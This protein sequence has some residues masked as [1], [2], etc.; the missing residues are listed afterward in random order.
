MA[1]RR[2]VTQG[3]WSVSCTT[4]Y[5]IDGAILHV[6]KSRTIGNRHIFQNGQANGLHFANS[7]LAFD[8]AFERGYLQEYFSGPV[9]LK[10]RTVHTFLGH[11]S[12]FCDVTGT[13]C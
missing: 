7:D 1:K 3:Q 13:F 11:R 12:G 4:G 9:C 8:F 5:G 2:T 6:F 10:C